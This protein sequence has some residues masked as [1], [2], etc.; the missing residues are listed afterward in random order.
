MLERFKEHITRQFPQLAEHTFLLACSGGMDSMVLLKLC[1]LSGLKFHVA[2]A[3]FRLRGKESDGD[4][5]FVKDYCE[6]YNIKYHVTSFD[7]IGYVN[8]NKVSVQVAARDL[9]YGWFKN[10]LQENQLSKVVTA[11]HADDDLETFIINLSRGTGLFGLSGIPGNTDAVARPLLRFDRDTLEKFAREHKLSWREDSSNQEIKYLRNRIR[12]EIVPP[13]K[14]THPAFMQNFLSTLGHLQDSEAIIRAHVSQL[15]NELFRKE[16]EIF[17]ISIEQLTTCNPLRPYLHFLFE[18]YGFIEGEPIEGLLQ[19]GSG[20]ILLSPTHRLVK[21]REDL[22][23]QRLEI[24]DNGIYTLNAEAG[25]ICEPV[26]LV[27]EEVDTLGN[28]GKH[29]LYVDKEKLNKELTLRKWKKGDY[30]YPFG[31]SGKKKLSKF[32]KDEKMDL[33]AKEKQWLLCSGDSIVWVLG[34]RPDDRFR[35][36]DNTRKILKITWVD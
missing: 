6:K 23:L 32:Y 7:T 2:H 26:Q 34:K 33:V 14:E 12:K 18:E 29:I 27:L 5:K 1:Q 21:D 8:E 9:R 22:L 28:T 31:L 35:V 3:N 16:G 17:R 15:K 19:S 11:H 24:Q 36:S 10:L 25:E 30:F 20:K 4:E 13:L